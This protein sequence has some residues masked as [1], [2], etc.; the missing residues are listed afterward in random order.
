MVCL[1]QRRETAIP[2]PPDFE[3]HYALYLHALTGGVTLGLTHAAE[4]RENAD[5]CVN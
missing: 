4:V 2:P 5:P 1:I 3:L